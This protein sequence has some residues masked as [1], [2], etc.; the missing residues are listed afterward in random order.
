MKTRWSDLPMVTCPHC[1]EV[2]QHEDYYDIK[3]GDSFDCHFCEKEIY[4]I[5]KDIIMSVNLSTEKEE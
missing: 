4:I 3:V 1:G 2:F 5:Q